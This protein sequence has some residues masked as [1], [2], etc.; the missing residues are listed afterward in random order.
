MSL[1]TD[2]SVLDA[3]KAE[4]DALQPLAPD[5]EKRLWRKLRLEWNYHS[6]HIEGNTLTYGETEL[7]LLH[8]QA[9][10]DH[11]LR[12]YEEMKAHDVGIEHLRRLASDRERPL[13]EGDIRDLNRII[14]KEAF[15]KPAQTADGK[16]SRKEIIPG[17]YKTSPNNVL[18]A[19]GEVFEFA[20][21][22]DTPPRM[23]VLVQW[24][25]DEITSGVLH[26]I[27]LAS[28]LHHDFV[29]IHPFDDGN[30]RV[31]RLL[32]NYVFLRYGYPPIVIRSEDKAAYLTALRKAD[33]GELETLIDYLAAALRGSLSLGI[34]AA[35]GESIEELSDVEKELALFVRAQQASKGNEKTPTRQTIAELIEVSLKPF[36]EKVEATLLKLRPLFRSLEI[37]VQDGLGTATNS[38]EAVFYEAFRFVDAGQQ[39]LV[40]FKFNSYQGNAPIPFDHHIAVGLHFPPAHYT[41]TYDHEVVSYPYSSPILGAQADALVAKILAS[42]FEEVKFKSGHWEKSE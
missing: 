10:G 25:G 36:I 32:V 23:Q 27:A 7:L 11:A 39:L 3:M 30:G 28:K 41:I 6:N 5:R 13:S 34:R 22:E 15:W 40:T 37:T 18:T 21:P 9:T 29:L 2:I 16:P 33:A 1:E 19:T 38:G 31:A 35:K 42:A 14:L 17:Q 20:S 8:G 26:P 24:L 12:E 4:W